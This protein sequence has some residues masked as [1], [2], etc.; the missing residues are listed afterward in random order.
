[1]TRWKGLHSGV[2]SEEEDD[3]MEGAPLAPFSKFGFYRTPRQFLFMAQRVWHPMDSANH[4]ET[5]TNYDLD[6]IFLYPAHVVKLER[7]KNLLQAKLLATKLAE[8]EKALHEGRPRPLQK[9]LQDKDLLVWK[10]LLEKYEYD[11]M[12][13]APFMCKGIKLVGKHDA[14]ACYPLLLKPATLVQEDLESSSVWRRK[15]AVGRVHQSDPAQVDH[16]DTTALEGIQLG[17]LEGPFSTEAGATNHLGRS[18]WCVVCWFVLVPRAEMKLRPIDD[19]WEA[20]L[21]NA[22]TVSSYLKLQDIDC[23]TGLA[24]RIADSLASGATGPGME[25]WLGKCLGLSKACK[26]T[27]IHPSY[28]PLAVIFY[29]DHSGAP[30][31]YVAGS[32]IFGASAAVYSFNRVSRSLWFILNKMPAIPCRVFYDYFPLFQPE[33]LAA[34]GDEAAS[35]LLDLLGWQHAKTGSKAA[36][37]QQR[38]DVLG[39]ALDLSETASSTLALENK[40]GRDDRL[41]TLLQQTREDGMLTRHQGRLV[42]GLLKYACGLFSGRYLH[43]GCAEVMALSSSMSRKSVQSV[44]PFCDYA[45]KSLQA[46]CPKRLH[47]AFE[48]RPLLIFADGCW[49]PDSAGFDAVIIDKAT[50]QRLVCSGVVPEVLVHK[51]KQLVGDHII[52]QIEMFVMVLLLW[53]FRSLLWNRRSNWWVDNESTRN[54]EIEGLSP[55]PTAQFLVREFYVLDADSPTYSWIELVPS[56]SNLPDG[57]SKHDCTEAPQVLG[58]AHVTPFEHPDELIGKLL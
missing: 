26:Q 18:G 38:F 30:K 49:E 51:W 9:V 5:V 28:R 58:I 47:S 52:R 33:S 20:Q 34:K 3:K 24:L 40:P 8:D 37:F 56:S 2:R 6:F 39:C 50:E 7:K 55:S 54:S 31:F 21:D 48:K 10:A 43:Q 23:V 22:C 15:A 14:P 27:N 42:L 35:Q 11:E 53:Q 19:C 29:Y 12:A 13:V 45:I 16:L 57:P 41:V 46:A 4:L 17:F 25:P 32:L 36:P 1:M 44:K